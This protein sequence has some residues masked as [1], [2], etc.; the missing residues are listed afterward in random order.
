MNHATLASARLLRV[1]S[2]LRDKREHS[3][4]DIMS[5]ARVAA[6]SAC[7]SELRANGARIDCV[8]RFDGPNREPRFYYTLIKEPKT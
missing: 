4:W 7:I 8:R 6:V 3:T 2:V 1:L 5:K